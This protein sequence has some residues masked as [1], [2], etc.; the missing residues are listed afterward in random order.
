[1]NLDNNIIKSLI[2]EYWSYIV[3]LVLCFFLFKSCSGG[4]ELKLA[5]DNLKLE[6]K[7]LVVS[8]NN[9][10]AKNAILH[11]KILEL[12]NKKQNVKTQ[13]VYI[14][15]KT[16]LA[17]KKVNTLN[18]IQ[19][20]KYYKERYKLPI[21][22]TQNGV[23]LSDTLSRKNITE[24]VQKDYCFAEIKL[25][26]VQLQLEE[27]K[28]IYKDTVID[29]FTKANLDLEKAISKQSTIILNAENLFKKEKNK[30]TFWKVTSG[31]LAAGA[32]YLLIT[33]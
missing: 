27:K 3:I 23:I 19:I 10:V 20:A 24:L 25:Y 28:G 12:E 31:I 8:S 6:V 16:K 1:M 11:K 7:D 32:G 5:N 9:H 18:T 30:Q 13:I 29:N 33:R 15:N 22:V 2:H 14:E 21:Q 17:I 26:K 4:E